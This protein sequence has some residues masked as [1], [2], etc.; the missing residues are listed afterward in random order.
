MTTLTLG[1]FEFARFE[2]P[3]NIP[4]GAEQKLNVHQ[5]VG[6]KRVIDALGPIPRNPSWS[7]W[8]VGENALARARYL[9]GF[10]ED[11]KARSL[12]WDELAFTVVVRS[13]ECDYKLGWRIPYTITCEVVSDDTAPVS[14]LPSPSPEQLV[15][16]DMANASALAANLGIPALTS[17]VGAVSSALSQINTFVGTARSQIRSVLQPLADAR[18]VAGSLLNQASATLA[19]V[20][21]LAS[22]NGAIPNPVA[23]FTSRLSLT[24]TNAANSGMLADLDS[25]LARMETNIAAVGSG[26]ANL[27]V[28]GGNLYALAAQ[29]YGDPMAWTALAQANGLA[30]PMISG[31]ATVVVPAKPAPADSTGVLNA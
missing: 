20:G 23:D 7:G 27:T 26:T 3:Q 9:K 31:I 18:A 12:T 28:A 8:F 24:A 19:N 21:N 6:G 25:H 14:A 1:D 16:D 4:F 11:G 10:A 15:G 30:D 22:L 2:I 17:A 5:L 29:E 13:V